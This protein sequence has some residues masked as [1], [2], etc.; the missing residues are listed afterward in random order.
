MKLY[1][2]YFIHEVDNTRESSLVRD[3]ESGLAEMR[4][5]YADPLYPQDPRPIRAIVVTLQRS[6]GLI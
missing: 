4:P 3:W 2:Y 6:R 5:P 1:A